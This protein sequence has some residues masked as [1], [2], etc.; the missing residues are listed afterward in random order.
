MDFPANLTRLSHYFV[1][2]WQTVQLHKILIFKLQEITKS[3]ECYVIVETFSQRHFL[4]CA[5][6]I[7]TDVSV[8]TS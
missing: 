2:P 8:L 6:V 1:T 3:T 7:C 5:A 4:C